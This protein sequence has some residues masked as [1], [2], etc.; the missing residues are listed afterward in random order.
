M[1]RALVSG[2]PRLLSAPAGDAG[3]AFLE[4]EIA[5]AATK[6]G[7]AIVHVVLAANNVAVPL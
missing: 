6:V 7:T 2:A 3:D 1:C 5:T 4:L